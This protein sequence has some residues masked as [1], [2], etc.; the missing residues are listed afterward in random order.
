M[1]IILLRHAPLPIEFQKRFI[2]HSN[3]EIDLLLADIS[4]LVEIKNTKFDMVYSSDLK[5]CTQT[6]DLINFEYEIDSRLREVKFKEIFEQKTF[7][8]IESMDIFEDKYLDCM[9]TWHE[10]ICEES[11]EEYKNR[12][13][14]FLQDLPKDKNI[15]I[16]SHAGT[17]KMLYKLL[18]NNELLEVDCLES[19]IIS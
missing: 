15:L 9:D 6:L 4:K 5:R 2:G 13:K 10:F 16:C 11:L 8:E 18:T 7:D 1:A 17:I 3:I 14:S 19:I 12:G